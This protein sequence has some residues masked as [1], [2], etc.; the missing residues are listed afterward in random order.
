MSVPEAKRTEQKRFVAVDKHFKLANSYQLAQKSFRERKI[1]YLKDLETRS[2]E[3][4]KDRVK[5]YQLV[6]RYVS[7]FHIV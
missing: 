1:K 4:N 2:S 3:A 6:A 5:C 7:S